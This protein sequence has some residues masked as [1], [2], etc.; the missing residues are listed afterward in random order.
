MLLSFFEH[1]KAKITIAVSLS[2]IGL[3]NIQAPFFAFKRY[4]F[5]FPGLTCYNERAYNL[6]NQHSYCQIIWRISKSSS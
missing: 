3:G 5:L 2:E 6:V 1:P 4:I